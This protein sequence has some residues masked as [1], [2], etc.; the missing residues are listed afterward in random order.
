MPSVKLVLML[1][2]NRNQSGLLVVQ[3]ARTGEVLRTFEALGRGSQGGGDTQL[4]VNGNTPTGE[5]KVTKAVPTGAWNQS[6]YGPS[7]ALRLEPK[8]GNAQVA[9]DAI[10]RDGLLIHGGSPGATGYWRGAGE[11]RATHGCV[12]LGNE[13]M[14]TL[15]E[16]LFEAT[17]DPVSFQS[18]DIDVS[19]TVTDHNMSFIRPR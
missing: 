3:N 16:T 9:E 14:R 13:D 12:R 10:G 6:S 1:S 4:Q 17:L 2:S 8:S 19:L 7:G 18:Q 15:V 5:Y 11:L